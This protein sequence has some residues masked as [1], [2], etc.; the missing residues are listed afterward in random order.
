MKRLLLLFAIAMLASCSNKAKDLDSSITTA[1]PDLAVEFTAAI[2]SSTRVANDVFE[3]NDVILVQAFEDGVAFESQSTYTYGGVNFEGTTNTIVRDNETQELSYIAAFPSTISSF[4]TSFDFAVNADQSTGDKYEFS[5]LLVATLDANTTT[6]PA[7]VFKH[8]LSSLIINFDFSGDNVA[9]TEVGTLKIYAKATTAVDLTADTYVASGEVVEL[10]PADNG[11]NSYKVIFAPQDISTGDLFAEYTVT[12]TGKT[13]T[14]AARNDLPFASTY[15]YT[16]TWAIDTTIDEPTYNGDVTLTAEI[17]DW[18]DKELTDDLYFEVAFDY[19]DESSMA[20]SVVVVKEGEYVIAPAVAPELEGYN[21]LGWVDA[22]NDA[23]NFDVPI[24]DETIIYASWEIITYSVAV[25]LNGGTLDVSAY[26]TTVNYGMTLSELGVPTKDSYEFLGWYVDDAEYN[27]ETI[28]TGDITITA[29][30]ALLVSISS[31][32]DLTAFRTLVNAGEDATS[33]IVTLTQDITLTE[34]DWTPI[35]TS[36]N[37]F[38]GSFDGGNN[39]IYDLTITNATTAYQGLFGAV[40]GGASIANCTI[41]GLS[42][43]T[44]YN[45]TTSSGTYGTIGAFA[46]GVVSSADYVYL[47]NLTVADGT[48]QGGCMVGGIIG[49]T[50]GYNSLTSGLAAIITDCTIEEDV[51]ITKTGGGNYLGG[52]VSAVK[53]YSVITNCQNKGAVI[54]TGGTVNGGILGAGQNSQIIGCS[55]VGS[56]TSS[57]NAYGGIMGTVGT[58]MTFIGCYNTGIVGGGGSNAGGI[59]GQVAAS[60]L[61]LY[62]CYG[63]GTMTGGNTGQLLG[64]IG[65]SAAD[66]VIENCY[67]VENAGDTSGSYNGVGSESGYGNF[68]ITPDITK[69][70]DIA[71]LNAVVSTMNANEAFSATD[72]FYTEGGDDNTPPS[73]SYASSSLN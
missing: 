56:V 27:F 12:A 51:T 19:G 13:Y 23:F 66:A 47:T 37:P 38:T 45:S 16:Y 18:D 65:G 7:L 39:T 68:T 40:G 4:G 41:S 11:T 14:W 32:S 9:E 55:N 42:I 22:A 44:T 30:W 71:G 35:G 72:Y 2:A 64:N 26:P 34:T 69:A 67:Y 70:D 3:T 54:S 48:I 36:T 57:A 63:A 5:D 46:G 62:A 21:F 29:K 52:I 73:I 15:R 24:T 33:A 1:E 8:A 6:T 59:G 58:N 17:G 20:D 60:G 53:N 61:K 50:S 25:E 43:K 49:A 31:E 28:V 10:T